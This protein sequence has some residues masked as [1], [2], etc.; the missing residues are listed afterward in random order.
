MASKSG[1][2]YAGMTNSLDRRVFEHKQHLI[3]GFTAKYHCTRLVYFEEFSDPSDAIAREKQIKGWLRS[4]KIALIESVNPHWHDL[5]QNLGA[6]MCPPERATEEMDGASS[7]C[8]LDP[9]EDLDRH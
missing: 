3:P 6:Q 5:A 8:K 2:L 4:K 7:K 9:L 1:T